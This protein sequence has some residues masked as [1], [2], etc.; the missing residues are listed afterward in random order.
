MDIFTKYTHVILYATFMV[1]VCTMNAFS[2]NEEKFQKAH[3][4]ISKLRY[5]AN[6]DDDRVFPFVSIFFKNNVTLRYIAV[7]HSFNEN[8]P[9]L[10]L[11]KEQIEDFQPTLIIVEGIEDAGLPEL[12]KSPKQS[13]EGEPQFTARLATEKGIKVISGEPT[14]KELIEK[15]HVH[16]DP[17]N[18]G[19]DIA[20]FYILRKLID[21]FKINPERKA[22][23]TNGDPKEILEE[24]IRRLTKNHFGLGSSKLGPRYDIL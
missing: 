6:V 5:S 10:N 11:V 7:Q 1:N 9:T 12:F 17:M 13:N 18:K 2:K 4:D 24:I 15:M 20:P 16:F 23:L 21:E 19:E 3:H 14:R 8:N 22:Q